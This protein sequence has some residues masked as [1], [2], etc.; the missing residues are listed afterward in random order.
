MS[1]RDKARQLGSKAKRAAKKADRELTKS[2]QRQRTGQ[3]LQGSGSGRLLTVVQAEEGDW[4]VRSD[5]DRTLSRHGTKQ[6]AVSAARQRAANSGDFKRYQVLRTNARNRDELVE[7]KKEYLTDNTDD[8][9][10]GSPSLPFMGPTGGGGS[11][12]DTEDGRSGPSLP[13]MAPPE[14]GGPQLPGAFGPKDRD[15]DD[16]FPPLF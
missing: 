2:A 1:F 14:D 15:D 5:A 11:E 12:R 16:D 10:G 3:G 6:A 13:F 7:E 9:R 4:L 8:Q